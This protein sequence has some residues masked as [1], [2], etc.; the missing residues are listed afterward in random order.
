MQV[1]AV[2]LQHGVAED[3]IVEMKIPKHNMTESNTGIAFIHMRDEA[4]ADLTLGLKGTYIG[5]R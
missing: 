5:D 3:D 1:K 2:V 4:A